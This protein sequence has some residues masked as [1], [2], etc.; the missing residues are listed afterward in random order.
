MSTNKTT[1]YY[2]KSLSDVIFHLKTIPQLRIYGGCTSSE[3][4]APSSLIINKINDFLLIDKHEHFM[5]FGAGVTLSQILNLGKKRIPSVLF[6]AIESI[7]YPFIRNAATIG[8]NICAKGIRHTLFAPLLALDT[9]LELQSPSSSGFIPMMKFHTVPE[10]CMISRIRIPSEEWD[11]AIFRRT[12]PDNTLSDASASFAFLANTHKGILSDL[13]IAFCGLV[14]I[15]SKELENNLIGTKL[16]LSDK[17]IQSMLI[18]AS[19]A[20][21]TKAAGIKGKDE[22][23]SLLEAQFLNLLSDSLSLLTL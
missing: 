5:E 20:F 8:G 22:V 21:M 14:S 7:A 17:A 15:R 13:R 10:N 2:A 23:L 11:I 1:V 6:D 4:L 19:S 9:H 12:G 16:P 3:K 18:E